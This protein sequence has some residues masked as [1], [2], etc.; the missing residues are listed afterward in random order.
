ML[1]THVLKCITCC[2]SLTIMVTF[3]VTTRDTS[4]ATCC[5]V[6][7]DLDKGYIN[8]AAYTYITNSI[9]LTAKIKIKESTMLGSTSVSVLHLIESTYA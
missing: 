8:H 2:Q 4:L 3:Q 9:I 1:D 5:L 6:Y 7:G